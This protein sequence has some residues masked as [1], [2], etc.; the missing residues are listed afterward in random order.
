VFLTNSFLW[1][2]TL[3]LATGVA[4]VAV[5]PRAAVL[6][7]QYRLAGSTRAVAISTSSATLLRTRRV[8]AQA[9]AITVGVPTQRVLYGRSLR[10]TTATIA[11][12]PNEA[13]LQRSRIVG[14]LK[15]EITIEPQSAGL[16]YGRV[17][18]TEPA[19]I[20]ITS[21]SM[22]FLK[23]AGQLQALPAEITVAAQDLQMRADRRLSAAVAAV[24]IAPQGAVLRRGYPLL[25][26]VSALT[27]AG[28]SA[29]LKHAHRLSAVV[30]AIAI[31]TNNAELTK[32]TNVLSLTQVGTGWSGGG[33]TT[34]NIT[35]TGA[36]SGD[37]VI[38][39]V[40]NFGTNASP[41]LPSGWTNLYN[42]INR[43]RW[44]AKIVTG[45][46]SIS[47]SFGQGTAISAIGYRPNKAIT[48]FAA[49]G[50]TAEYT[51]GNPSSDTVSASGG[52]VPSLIVLGAACNQDGV[53]APFSTA[54]PAFDVTKQSP[55]GDNDVINLG[56]KLYNSSPANHS[57]DM[58]D[59]G[60]NILTS[61]YVT[62]T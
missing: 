20:E 25:A 1:R 32:T 21:R 54:S 29:A 43:V 8:V 38:C 7:R 53:A 55:T 42:G 60:T 61:G 24:E 47:S 16:H 41:A 49:N 15:T 17:I 11:V 19:A 62:V 57:I 39:C 9:A 14:F 2:K 44:F 28:Q 18:K 12:A 59:L 48:S 45:A 30:R 34:Y 13:T 50:F 58:N 10:G 4:A 23:V 36:Q 37:L 52:A 56:A 40:T 26:S 33:V 5:T 3:R 6:A 46:E 35:P 51:T 27:V 22:N 31:A